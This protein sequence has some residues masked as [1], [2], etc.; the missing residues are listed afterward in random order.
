[1]ALDFSLQSRS[2]GSTETAP[3]PSGGNPALDGQI[4]EGEYAHRYHDEATGVTVHWTILGEEIYFGLR[5]QTNGWV[6]L[7]LSPGGPLM[8]GGDIIIGCVS[9]GELNIQDNYAD[10]PTIHKADVEL[11]G[12]DDILE[13]AGSEDQGGT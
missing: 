10:G 3:A 5:S 2:E 13:A 9:A 4:G 11:G 1:L 12:S 7:S 6:A 8:G